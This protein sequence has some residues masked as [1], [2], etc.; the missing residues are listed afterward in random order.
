M[1]DRSGYS[2]YMQVRA[3]QVARNFACRQ[4]D[5]GG[6]FGAERDQRAS[7]YEKLSGRDL[8]R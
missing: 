4:I 2:T 3:Q 8:C 7:P 6:R 5:R 1:P